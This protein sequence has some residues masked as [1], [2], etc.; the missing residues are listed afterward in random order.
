MVN[1]THVEDVIEA[2]IKDGIKST[3]ATVINIT[4]NYVIV[5]LPKHRPGVYFLY[6]RTNKGLAAFRYV[7]VQRYD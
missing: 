7:I 5:R 6:L 2:Y 4:N 3:Q 1:V